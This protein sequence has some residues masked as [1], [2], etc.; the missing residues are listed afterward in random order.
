MGLNA[1]NVHRNLAVIKT[2]GADK[3][4]LT[5]STAFEMWPDEGE[6]RAY[7]IASNQGLISQADGLLAKATGEERLLTVASSH[8]SAACRA[9]DAGC[10]TSEAALKDPNG[11]LNLIQVAGE[12]KVLKDIVQNGWTFTIVPWTAE[13][14]WPSLPDLAQSA[15]NAEHSTFSVASELQAMAMIAMHAGIGD[16]LDWDKAVT[17]TKASMPP[18]HAYLDMLCEFVKQYGGGAGAPMVRYLDAFAKAFGENKVI[19][20]QF[21]TSV[22]TLK[23]QAASTNFPYLRTALMAAQ[24]APSASRSRA[25]QWRE[26]LQYRKRHI[27]NP[28]GQSRAWAGCRYSLAR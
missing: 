11:R 6:Q 23:F 18:C 17:L 14:I 28:T 21:I 16:K 19:G 13:K 1:F 8:F 4:H 10:I 5:K 25:R 22:V 26:A 20:E 2:V 12:D 24:F 9:I 7:Q 3:Q 15:L 27:H